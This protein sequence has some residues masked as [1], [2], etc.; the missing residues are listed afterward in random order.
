MDLN[1]IK[2]QR[3]TEKKLDKEHVNPLVLQMDTMFIC[4][5]PVLHLSALSIQWHLVSQLFSSE[6]LEK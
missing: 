4:L 2:N 6:D 1:T 3:E 5:D